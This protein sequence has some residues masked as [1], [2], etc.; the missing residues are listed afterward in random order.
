MENIR[1]KRVGTSHAGLASGWITAMFSYPGP[2][3]GMITAGRVNALA[4]GSTRRRRTFPDAP[5]L[6]SW[7]GPNLRWTSG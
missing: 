6:P 5:T 4:T 1:Y 2:A 7:V 3:K